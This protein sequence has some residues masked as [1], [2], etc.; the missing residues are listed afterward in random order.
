MA[1]FI[2]RVWNKEGPAGSSWPL[3]VDAVRVKTNG[4]TSILNPGLFQPA[5]LSLSFMWNLNAAGEPPEQPKEQH[6]EQS[7]GALMINTLAEESY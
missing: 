1:P 6:V 4:C 7:V 3:S 2:V 5:L